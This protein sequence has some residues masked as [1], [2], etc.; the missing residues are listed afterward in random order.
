MEDKSNHKVAKVDGLLTVNVQMRIPISVVFDKEKDED[1]WNSYIASKLNNDLEHY[2]MNGGYGHW[3]DKNF[4]D[5]L[6]SLEELIIPENLKYVVWD[7]FFTK[8]NH[9]NAKEIWTG[10]DSDNLVKNVPLPR[11]KK[12][13]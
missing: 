1:N 11:E 13:A 10:E 2:E 9:L 6:P 5:K 7:K 12:V 4:S 8:T 3:Y